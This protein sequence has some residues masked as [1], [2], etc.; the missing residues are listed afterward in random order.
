[1]QWQSS[2]IS[3]IPGLLRLFRKTQVNRDQ[4]RLTLQVPQRV[5]NPDAQLARAFAR[6]LAFGQQFLRRALQLRAIPPSTAFS[7][8]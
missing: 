7:A 6:P 2:R 8:L 5:I 1:M 3:Y 4:R